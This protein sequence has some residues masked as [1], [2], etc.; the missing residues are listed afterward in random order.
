MNSTDHTLRIR[1]T[2]DTAEIV[3]ASKKASNAVKGVG[4]Q[5]KQTT[6][7]LNRL[8]SATKRAAG[9]ARELSGTYSILRGAIAGVGI[10]YGAT[11]LVN[12]IGETQTLNIRLKELSGSTEE[13][14]ANQEFLRDSARKLRK[15]YFVLGDGYSK[16][17]ALQKGGLTTQKESK[18][19]L[20]GLADAA[21]A[22]GA[23]NTQLGQSLFG[24]SQGLASSKLKMEEL[25]Q[26]TEPMPGLLQAMD[27]SLG[28]ASGGFRQMVLDGQVTS[29]FFK[30]TLIKAF[31]EFEGASERAGETIPGAMTDIG[32]AYVEVAGL[33]EQPISSALV[34]VLESVA[35]GLRALPEYADEAKT[36]LII[37]SSF[38]AAKF[39]PAL[40]IS[41]KATAL[42][43]AAAFTTTGV[44]TNNMGQ[45][46]KQATVLQ[47]GL[48]FAMAGLPG[49][50]VGAA[51]A[52]GSFIF[53]SD[54]G[55][56]SAEDFSKKV[57]ALL[58]NFS[59][60][61][62]Q[63][64]N[65]S[66][67]EGNKG[68][69]ESTIEVSTLTEQ[70]KRLNKVVK[71]SNGDF[72]DAFNTDVEKLARL[73]KQ[74]SESLISFSQY[75]QSVVEITVALKKMSKGTDGA[76]DSTDR[77][78]KKTL[79]TKSAMET[80]SKTLATQVLLFGKSKQETR[81]LNVELKISAERAKLSK[82]ATDA[83]II[84]F[85]E[86]ATK[87]RESATALNV[88]SSAQESFE[89]FS[90]QN[91]QSAQII[92]LASVRAKQLSDEAGHYAASASLRANAHESRLAQINNDFIKE[93]ALRIASFELERQ[94]ELDSYEQ[95]KNISS[96]KFE[97]Q[98][99]LLI[100]RRELVFEKKLEDKGAERELLDELDN[101]QR[102]LDA[103]KRLEDEAAVSIHENNIT[104]IK[105]A[106]AEERARLA[107]AVQSAEINA[108]SSFAGSSLRLI[109]S[110]GSQSFKTKKRYAIAQSIIQIT[111]GVAQALNNPYPANIGFAASV[112]AAGASLVS[113][114]RSTNPNSGSASLSLSG[115]PS[116]QSNN[117]VPFSSAPTVQSNPSANDA[118]RSESNFQSGQAATIINIYET[119]AAEEDDDVLIRRIEGLTI[120]P[121]SRFV[122]TMKNE[123]ANG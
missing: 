60:L 113:T 89:Q 23:D 79:T 74:L 38:A 101:Q 50:A 4:N 84:S 88:L 65:K 45:K 35:S 90:K 115:A 9:P 51:V 80:Y 55:A 120:N 3:G 33:L 25:N 22:L 112:A 61:K 27:K 123:V 67:K 87:A 15:D 31:A 114:I 36:L 99:A 75:K 78:G 102:E 7:K 37:L 73:K 39:I 42:S 103:A 48:N 32:N 16:I 81:L 111:A 92:D 17:L 62:E 105:R 20:I 24:M 10:A 5:S 18:Q 72:K 2:G 91:Q 108:Y 109:E 77:H 83:Q 56:E 110:F 86:F 95:S 49:L 13:Y 118:T 96:A 117:V 97:E 52:I 8:N 85:E 122:Q 63:Q 44:A 69:E 26:V 19:L 71:E 104:E 43:A 54:D 6:S 68:L 106:Q 70:I 66:L 30:E 21:S 64:L 116:S 14:A 11:K 93:G 107:R 40:F 121:E 100:E 34:P 58:G 41:M 28:L 82:F 1:I 46:L 76:S 119:K 47:R 29:S 57:D 53:A 12:T 98:Q 94:L 59:K